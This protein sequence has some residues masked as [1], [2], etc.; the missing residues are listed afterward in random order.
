MSDTTFDP[1]DPRILKIY[2]NNP[3][4]VGIVSKGD[5]GAGLG[6]KIGDTK[7]C[8]YAIIKGG[9]I[10]VGLGKTFDQAEINA[11]SNLCILHT[12]NIEIAANYTKI[13]GFINVNPLGLK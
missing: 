3:I 2:R 1:I 10:K 9:E 8:F 5:G 13:G 7:F 11:D 6:F 4:F 12:D